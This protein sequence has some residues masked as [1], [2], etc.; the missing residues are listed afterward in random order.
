[1]EY[2]PGNWIVHLCPRSAWE[3]AVETGEYRPHSLEIEGFIHCSRPD[4]IEQVAN[5]FYK[6]EPDLVLLWIDIY[7][8]EAEI[9]WEN[10]DDQTYPH[11]YGTLNLNAVKAAKSYSS[12]EE[13]K[14]P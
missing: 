9:R 13:I 5:R 2:L 1:M 8:L 14:W 4:Q 6:D 10:A 11:L 3:Q 7:S 12:T